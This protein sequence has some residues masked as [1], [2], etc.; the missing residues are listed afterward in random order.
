VEVARTEVL[1]RQKTWSL[2]ARSSTR[3]R[4]PSSRGLAGA[5]IIAGAA[6]LAAASLLLAGCAAAGFDRSSV[7]DPAWNCAR[8]N[9]RWVD[10]GFTRGCTYGGR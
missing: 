1:V 8:Q 4:P 6:R 2:L 3:R 10:D 9:G 5:A 7:N